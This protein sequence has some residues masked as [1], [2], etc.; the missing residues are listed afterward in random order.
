MFHLSHND[1]KI[2]DKI[3]LGEYWKIQEEFLHAKGTNH[4]GNIEYNLDLSRKNAY[5]HL[6]SRLTSVCRIFPTIQAMNNYAELF[7]IACNH[8][9][10]VDFAV[11]DDL[12]FKGDFRALH[13][14]Y[15]SNSQIIS[16]ET[17]LANQMLFKYKTLTHYFSST[18][19]IEQDWQ[20]FVV[21]GNVT[22]QAML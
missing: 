19:E 18:V 17:E 4:I 15:E 12:L 6:P 8:R 3:S 22:I 5:P 14:F 11:H 1:Y 10:V 13:K 2:G 7:Q 9:Y 20:E 21:C 16:D